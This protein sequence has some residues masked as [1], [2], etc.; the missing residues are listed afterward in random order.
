[1]FERIIHTDDS[2]TTILIRLIV[3]ARVGYLLMI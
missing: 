1:M 2:G 3:G